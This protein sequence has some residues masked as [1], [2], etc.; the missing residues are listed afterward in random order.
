[1]NHASGHCDGVTLEIEIGV[2]HCR[3]I[4]HLLNAIMDRKWFE[5]SFTKAPISEDTA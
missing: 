5:Y 1:M 2:V 4:F 3:G